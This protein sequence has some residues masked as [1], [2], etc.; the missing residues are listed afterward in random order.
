MNENEV[1]VTEQEDVESLEV[2]TGDDSE[3]EEVRR[4]DHIG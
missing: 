1:P 2:I 4:I 3:E